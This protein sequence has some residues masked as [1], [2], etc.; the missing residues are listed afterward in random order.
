[1]ADRY[2]QFGAALL[3]VSLGFSFFAYGY[4][5][6][7]QT[8]TPAGTAQ[9]FTSI[10]YPAFLAYLVIAAEILGGLAL[11]LGVATRVVALGLIPLMIGA[12]L[13]HVGNGWVFSAAGG[14]WSYPA[15]WTVLLV[16]QALLGSGRFA[17]GSLLK[18]R[19]GPIAA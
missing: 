13:Q 11:I 2:T 3:R 15:L 17:V 12:T 8:F 1:M 19:L 9:Y 4:F 7:Y 16:V 5:L 14:G 10:G 6:K 18:Q